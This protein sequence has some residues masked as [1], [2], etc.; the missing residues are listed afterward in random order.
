MAGAS[1]TALRAST[2][3]ATTPGGTEATVVAFEGDL[4]LATIDGFEETVAQA[5]ETG[6]VIDLGAVRFID[7][8][9][10]HCVVR[11]RLARVESDLRVELVVEPGS[12]VD[13]VLEMSGLRDRLS[14][15]ADRGAAL[16]ALDGPADDAVPR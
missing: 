10:I 7:S 5:G 11:S 13:R 4:D 3:A 14:P 16:A 1:A 2:E 9:G 15:K 8:S 6:L 12:A